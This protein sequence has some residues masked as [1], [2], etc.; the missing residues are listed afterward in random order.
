MRWVADPFAPRARVEPRAA[1]PGDFERE[2][3]VAGSDPRAAHR[4]HGGGRTPTQARAP[5]TAELRG[6][7]KLPER[8]EVAGV[9]MVVCA[10]DMAR[11]RV[12]GLV[13]AGEAIGATRVDQ[14]RLRSCESARGERR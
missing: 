4:D 5:G 8:V 9:G 6:R 14:E 2:Q 11:D 12:D 3:I 13:L 10:R 7:A 1:E